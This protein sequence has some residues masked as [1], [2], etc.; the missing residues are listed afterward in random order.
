MMKDELMTSVLRGKTI[1]YWEL[2]NTFLAT[3]HK[4]L[5]MY[6]PNSGNVGTFFKFE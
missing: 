1:V 6:N 3:W 5:I 4:Q 2:Y